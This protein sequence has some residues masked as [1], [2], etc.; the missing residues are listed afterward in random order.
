[1]RS[2]TD[3]AAARCNPSLGPRGVCSFMQRIPRFS[4]RS[5]DTLYRRAGLLL[6]R[7]VLNRFV[8]AKHTRV[9]RLGGRP[10]KRVT[11][12]DSHVASAVARNL[13]P[14]RDS[15]VFPRLIAI[16]DNELVLEFVAGTELTEPIDR[17]LVDRFVGFFSV[18]YSVD[19]KRVK[20][21]ETD[22]E[23]ELRENLDFLQDVSILSRQLRRDL[24]ASQERI[25]PNEVWVGYDYLDPL[26]KNFILT[27][28][29]RLVAVDVEDLCPDRLIGGGVAK[30]VLRAFPAD[31]EQLLDGLAS[32]ANLELRPEMPF[33]ELHFLAQWTQCA[34]LK[35]SEKLIDASLFE[36]HRTAA[37]ETL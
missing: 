27:N 8:R 35:G 31:R 17:A 5:L 30:S 7:F 33:I 14:F 19:R 28:D 10:Y 6:R 23:R 11:L 29:D 4:Q 13:M 12:P 1:M 16:E 26:L 2:F 37:I 24:A 36:S 25:T 15:G 20:L 22:F 34:F 21:S 32:R 3:V 9:V 18:I